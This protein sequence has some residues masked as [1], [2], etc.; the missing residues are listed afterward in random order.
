MLGEAE[1]KLREEGVSLWLAA[2]SPEA[3]RMV[4]ASP[5]GELLGRERMLFTVEQAVQRFTSTGRQG[6]ESHGK[7]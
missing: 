1:A 6:V 7:E 3:L 5:L 4:Q 2:L